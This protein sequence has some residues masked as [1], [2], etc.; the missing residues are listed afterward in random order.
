MRPRLLPPGPWLIAAIVA[1]WLTGCASAGS[2]ATRY[3]LPEGNM[4]TTAASAPAEHLLLVRPPRLAHYLD[5]D[6]IVLQLDDITLNEAR[7]HQWAEAL[8]RQLERGL[9]ARLASRLTDTRVL[10][11]DRN[12]GGAT[13]ITLR[14]E[15]DRFQGRHDGLA[16]AGGQWQ[17]RGADG[18]LLAM[19]GFLVETELDADGYPAL[20]RALGRSWDEVAD[21]I[22]EAVRRQ[23]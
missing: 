19:D 18:R 5:V 4:G 13:A 20:V 21:R 15:V 1:L 17:L 16:V 7:E 14:L 6:G 12:E 8:G 23:R 2:S 9:R 22:A 3:L 10:L 11:D